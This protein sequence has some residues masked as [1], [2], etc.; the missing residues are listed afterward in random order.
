MIVGLLC[1]RVSIAASR[2]KAPLQEC[3]CFHV[4]IATEEEVAEDVDVGLGGDQRM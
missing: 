4:I 1:C 3:G 2:K